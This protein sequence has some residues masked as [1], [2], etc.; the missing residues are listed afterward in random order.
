M[1]AK[2]SGRLDIS[3]ANDCIIDVGGVGYLVFCSGRTLANLGDAGNAVTLLIE[4]HVR[5]DHIHLYGFAEAA[6]RDWFKLLLSVQGVGAKVALAILSTLAPGELTQAVLA[7][8]KSMPTRAP[9]VGPKLGGRIVS[10]LKDKVGNLALGPGAS[11]TTALPPAQGPAVDAISA[12]VNLGYRPAEAQRAVQTAAAT[13]GEGV[14]LQSLIRDSLRH[15]A[16]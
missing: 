3:G 4:T 8:D 7:Q 16:S 15:L 1:I 14:E 5:E 2:L 6:E 9:G 12:L 10:E 13:L 11:D